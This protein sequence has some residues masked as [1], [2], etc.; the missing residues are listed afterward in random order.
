MRA[1]E[2]PNFEEPPADELHESLLVD[3]IKQLQLRK[4]SLENQI[5][6]RQNKIKELEEQSVQ[7]EENLPAAPPMSQAHSDLFLLQKLHH[8][9]MMDVI[10]LVKQVVPTVQGVE[11]AEPT[12]FVDM[13]LATDQP[14]VQEEDDVL[15]EVIK[16]L[17]PTLIEVGPTLLREAVAAFGGTTN[18]EPTEE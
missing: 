18:D 13:D 5:N 14:L 9:A 1:E 12:E 2:A 16:N 4:R 7:H 6:Y 15:G 8:G 3:R 10:E 17:A 11:P